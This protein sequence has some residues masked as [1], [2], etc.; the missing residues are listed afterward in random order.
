MFCGRALARVLQKVCATILNL[1]VPAKLR[2]KSPFLCAFAVGFGFSPVL[3]IPRMLQ[4]GIIAGT[5]YGYD[6]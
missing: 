3:N 6:Y 1:F 5:D 4:L 2:E